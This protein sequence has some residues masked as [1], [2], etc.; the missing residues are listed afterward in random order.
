[1]HDAELDL[2]F[3]AL[4]HV[5]RRRILTSLSEK[6]GQ[7]LFEIC[8]ASYGG[9]GKTLSRQTVSQHLDMLER[10][11]LIE[12]TWQGRTKMH[13]INENPLRNAIAMLTDNYFQES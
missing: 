1:M 8:A 3:K 10:A 7:S 9:N 11:R 2:V 6:P 13:A 12:V 5:E 4:A